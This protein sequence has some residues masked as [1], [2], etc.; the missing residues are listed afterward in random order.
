MSYKRTEV[1][2]LLGDP[3]KARAQLGWQPRTSF[4]SLV[5]EMMANDLKLAQRDALVAG[6]GFHAP[7]YHE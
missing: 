6:A 1:E 2:T 7:N 4:A 3:S 5:S